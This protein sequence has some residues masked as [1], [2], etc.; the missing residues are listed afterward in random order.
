MTSGAVLFCPGNACLPRWGPT[1]RLQAF[2]VSISLQSPALRCFVLGTHW[3]ARP[4][5]PPRLQDSVMYCVQFILLPCEHEGGT[6]GGRCHGLECSP[7][8][9]LGTDHTRAAGTQ[10][11]E[12]TADLSL[13]RRP[14]GSRWLGGKPPAGRGQE[15]APPPGTQDICSS[16]RLISV[17]WPDSYQLFRDLIPHR[18]LA[19]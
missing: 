17:P 18:Y 9:G 8:P 1:F 12:Q 19:S 16:S 6:S 5:S 10:R 15:A 4:C 13:S 14:V 2:P 11:E 3:S 7:H